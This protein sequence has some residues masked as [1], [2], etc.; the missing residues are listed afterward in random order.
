VG[1]AVL[2]IIL[3]TSIFSLRKVLFL[4]PAVVFRG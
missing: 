2:L 3:L 4:E 1:L